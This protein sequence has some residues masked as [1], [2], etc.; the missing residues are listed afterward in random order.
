VVC[1]LRLKEQLIINRFEYEIQDEAEET[2]EYRLFLCAV[3]AEAEET[4]EY[5]LF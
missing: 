1:E 5:R 3:G 4:I 2:I